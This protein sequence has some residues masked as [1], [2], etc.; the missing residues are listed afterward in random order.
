MLRQQQWPATLRISATSSFIELLLDLRQLHQRCRKLL[1]V[2]RRVHRRLLIFE[3]VDLL[4]Q[5]LLLR[6]QRL[7]GGVVRLL[8]GGADP[9]HGEVGQQYA[10]T[11]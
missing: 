1:L 11:L 8:L 3:R 4:F 2:V 10:F 6:Q 7:L 9:Q 5:I